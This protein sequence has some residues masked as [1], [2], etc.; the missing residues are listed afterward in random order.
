MLQLRMHCKFRPPEVA[1]VVLGCFGRIFTERTVRTKC[2]FSAS[3]QNILKTSLD[4]T[5]PISEKVQ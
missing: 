4:S 1:P 3:D 2:Y 5:S